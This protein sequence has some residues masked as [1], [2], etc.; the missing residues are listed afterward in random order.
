MAPP[1]PRLT[2]APPSQA[3]SAPPQ[4]QSVVSPGQVIS[5]QMA[6]RV[7]RDAVSLQLA[8]RGFD[9]L[10]GTALWLVAELAADFTRAIGH[11]L[12]QVAVPSPYTDASLLPLVRRCKSAARASLRLA[13]SHTARRPRAVRRLQRHTLLFQAAEWNYM[14]AIFA[15]SAVRRQPRRRGQR[16]ARAPCLDRRAAGTEPA[17][18]PRAEPR[19]AAGQR[20]RAGDPPAPFRPCGTAAPRPCPVSPPLPWLGRPFSHP[21]AAPPPLAGDAAAAAVA[22]RAAAAQGGAG[23]LRD[24]ARRVALQADGR[25]AHGAVRC[26]R[27]A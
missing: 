16:A 9:G 14:S 7:M 13:H 15:R 12:A 24:D 21:R 19:A 5:R 3:Q 26:V 6:Y 10:R 20:L 1:H 17:V 27:T 18:P 25:G 23:P 4:P 11:Q 2:R 8:R 22:R